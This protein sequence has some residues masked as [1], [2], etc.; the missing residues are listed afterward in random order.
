MTGNNDIVVAGRAD[1]KGEVTGGLRTF[2][3]VRRCF[4]VAD[5]NCM[6]LHKDHDGVGRQTTPEPLRGCFDAMSFLCL[7]KVSLKFLNLAWQAFLVSRPKARA[8]S[9]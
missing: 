2:V 5:R 8:A 9:D 6:Q 1:R 4:T 7:M 3:D